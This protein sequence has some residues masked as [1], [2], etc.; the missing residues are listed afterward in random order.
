MSKYSCWESDD[1]IL[2]AYRIL[3]GLRSASDLFHMLVAICKGRATSIGHFNQAS[4]KI[5][6][7]FI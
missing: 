5:K 1:A 6:V 7:S 4:G 3:D 2:H